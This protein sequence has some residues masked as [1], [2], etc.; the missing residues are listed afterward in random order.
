[1]SKQQQNKPQT[2]S[3]PEVVAQTPDGTTVLATV[4]KGVMTAQQ[5]TKA[6]L[7]AANSEAMLAAVADF[8]DRLRALGE[9]H[10]EYAD[11]L[12][13]L[14]SYTESNI[15]GM[16][17]ER[18]PPIVHLQMKQASTR[19]AP[20]KAKAGDWY[21]KTGDI[22]GPSFTFI[23]VLT[24]RKRTYFKQGQ[25]RPEC[26]SDDGNVGSKYGECQHC[27]YGRFEEGSK[28]SCS[29]GYAFTVLKSDFSELYALDFMKTSAK[30][31]KQLL[32]MLKQPGI[33]AKTYSITSEKESN[34]RGV[35]YVARSTPTGDS[36]TGAELEIAREVSAF[37]RLRYEYFRTRRGES[38]AA[39]GVSAGSS[40]GALPSGNAEMSSDETPDV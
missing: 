2:S 30:S 38:N 25:E 6:A 7:A 9:K 18:M 24:H 33:F 36:L 26:V 11:R 23:P 28:S 27:P 3:Q 29:A 37:V 32:G 21:T 16:V 15:E 12:E 40:A 20:E 22:L 8:G 39:R 17:E 14:A 1:M 34:D 5:L 31:G 4:P 35:F 19:S 13:T 10:P